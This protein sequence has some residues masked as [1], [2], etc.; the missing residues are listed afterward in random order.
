MINR[1]EG[2]GGW[3]DEE[4]LHGGADRLCV[5]VGGTG[6]T[7]I[8]S[9]PEARDCGTDFTIGRVSL[10]GYFLAT[11]SG[12]GSWRR[13]RKTQEACGGY[14]LRYADAAGYTDE[15]DF[16]VCREA[17]SRAIPARAFWN[18]QTQ[19]LYSIANQSVMASE[20]ANPRRAGFLRIRIREIASV[21]KRCGY[22]RTHVLLL[23][24]GGK[25]TKNAFSGCICKK[26]WTW[27]NLKA[28]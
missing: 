26:Y 14:W 28:E 9:M 6:H 2:K 19:A 12:F 4:Q 22:R 18:N 25:S 1:R 11:W 10:A 13:E 5:R 3:N 21:W 17:C 24:E 23:L 8:G 15:K 20:A 27:M 7:D 16:K